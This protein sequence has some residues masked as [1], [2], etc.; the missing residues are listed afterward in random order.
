[1]CDW[2]VPG[3][4]LKGQM[5]RQWA[6]CESPEEELNGSPGKTLNENWLVSG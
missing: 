4:R 3:H 5:D 1:M 2:L 6:E